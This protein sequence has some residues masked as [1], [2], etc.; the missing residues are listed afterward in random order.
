MTGPI[1]IDTCNFAKEAN[2][3]TVVD[4]EVTNALEKAGSLS[5]DRDKVF[6]EIVEAKSDISRLTID[7]LLIRDLKV[8]SGIPIVGLPMLVKVF[9]CF[10]V[11]IL[12]SWVRL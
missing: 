12:V 8:A 3:A 1:L 7:D 4:V 2:R 5:L 11:R 9:H 10:F 6:N